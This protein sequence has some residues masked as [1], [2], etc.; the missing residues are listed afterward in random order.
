MWRRVKEFIGTIYD[1]D[2]EIY[3]S[4]LSFYTIFSIIPL[5]L[6]SFTVYLKFTDFDHEMLKDFILHNLIPSKQ[7]EIKG[8]IDQF[9]ANSSKLG[10]IGV[11]FIIFASLMFFQNYEQVVNKIFLTKPKPIFKAIS[12][13][14]TLVTLTPVA[15]AISIYLITKIQRYIDSPYLDLLAIFSYLVIWIL[16][17]I[18]YLISINRRMTLKSVFISSFV[19]SLIW[20]GSK[21]IFVYYVLYNKT[22]ST[23]YGSFSTILFFFLWIYI[24]WLIYLYGVKLCYIMNREN[25]FHDEEYADDPMFI[26]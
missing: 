21:L 2:I 18:N 13:Y 12:T 10:V 3:A 17:F 22:Y 15:L 7:A 19:A 11:V 20:Y 24:S 6:V 26:D 23:L 25:Y 14:W 1:P 8:Y 9:L 16:F 5:L 4:S